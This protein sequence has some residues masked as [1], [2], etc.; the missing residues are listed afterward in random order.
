MYRMKAVRL[1]VLIIS[2]ISICEIGS[3]NELLYHEY[4]VNPLGAIQRNFEVKKAIAP[5]LTSTDFLEWTD[6]LNR[7]SLLKR[8]NQVQLNTTNTTQ[9]GGTQTSPSSAF[10]SILSALYNNSALQTN[11]GTLNVSQL[12]S[13]ILGSLSPNGN[14]F[15]SSNGSQ[16]TSSGNGLG[17]T[18][19]NILQNPDSIGKFITQMLE[20]IGI[21]G[22]SGNASQS[23]SG[24]PSNSLVGGLG[25]TIQNILQNPDTIGK[26]IS[27]LTGSGGTG[28]TSGLDIANI[29]KLLTTGNVDPNSA[30]QMFM[31]YL[32]GMMKSSNA[33]LTCQSD[34]LKVIS[35]LQAR[36]PWALKMLDA[37]AKIPTGVMNLD[38]NWYGSYDECYSDSTVV[39]SMG[40][41]PSKQSPVKGQYCTVSLNLPLPPNVKMFLAALQNP[42]AIRA[43]MCFPKSCSTD[44]LLRAVNTFL[45][46]IPLGESRVTAYPITCPT[47]AEDDTLETS[48][49]VVVVI[50]AIFLILIL[51]GTLYDVIMVIKSRRKKAAYEKQSEKS[52]G[53]TSPDSSYKLRA[54][55]GDIQRPKP[56]EKKSEPGILGKIM[57]SFSAYTNGKK[58]L[59]TSQPKGS[60]TAVNGIRFLSMSWVILGHTLAFILGNTSNTLVY[61][62]D[63][64]GR[65]SSQVIF[66]ALVSVDTFF[67][68]SG[69]LTSYL[70]LKQMSKTKG[71][72]N[73]F[74][75]Y[76]HR[77]WRLTPVYM[78]VIGMYV[79][80]Y[81]HLIFGPNK[82]A[83]DETCK[84][85]WWKNLL[86]IDNFFGV[87]DLCL[88]WSWYL[89]NDMQFYVLSPLMI[90]PLFF[91]KIAGAVVTLVFLLAATITP[92]VLS[93][94]KNLPVHTIG[95]GPK[96]A[97]RGAFFEDY[98]IVPYCRMG[99][100]ICGVATGYILY[101]TKCKCR[102]NIFL[103]LLGWAVAAASAC[104]VLYGIYDTVKPDQPVALSKEV[105]AL[106][107]ALNRTV[108][109]A[110]VCWVIFAC[111]TGNGG[112]INTL[113]SWKAFVPLSRLTYCAYLIHPLVM[114]VYYLNRN[115]PF[116][117]TDLDMVYTFLANLMVSYG[118]AFILSIAFESPFMGLE[119]VMFGGRGKKE[120]K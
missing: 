49:I 116:Y 48:A 99:P 54:E 65:V 33:S 79:T 62:S 30:G 6:Q 58:I 24:S 42:G 8:A 59:G 32:N 29:L 55:L 103:N 89:N 102:M 10:Q 107:N 34:L 76:F 11:N 1:F 106:Y 101:K 81:P 23:S 47:P 108:W 40:F 63:F 73:W 45:Y 114:Y 72:I 37:S 98:Y 100:Y 86:Y 77:F 119:K 109:G 110:A 5:F 82:T 71:R 94:V 3:G 12:I 2:L 41:L 67:V 92:G 50:L 38:L 78:M 35:G 83:P 117:L 97:D 91:D 80:I 85:A 96:D 17:N 53:F 93:Y 111:A 74:L 7:H 75:F 9:Q 51:E 115:F 64:M 120:A 56:K 46:A 16:S 39:G 13:S 43:G 61:Y 118:V 25:K 36:E 44:D 52:N 18:I 28:A 112:Y 66:N 27:Q 31:L 84:R 15:Q 90:V 70:L 60:L 69:L 113:L 68:L 87:K 104:A 88:G 14:S 57:L 26:I 4:A 19:Q 22:S 21:G 105:A 95:G 20:S